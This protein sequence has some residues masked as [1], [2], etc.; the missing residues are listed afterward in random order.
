MPC[1]HFLYTLYVLRSS[2]RLSHKTRYTM[3]TAADV[4]NMAANEVDVQGD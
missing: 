3:V 4:S 1:D 2:M